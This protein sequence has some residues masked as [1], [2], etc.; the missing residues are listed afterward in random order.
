V[1]F[2]VLPDY[3]PFKIKSSVSPSP[4]QRVGNQK[5]D[6]VIFNDVYDVNRLA[7][8]ATVLKLYLFYKTIVH[9][10]ESCRGVFEWATV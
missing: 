8:F 3:S 1:S 10:R 9:Y 2:S 4:H 5:L 6:L 7:Q